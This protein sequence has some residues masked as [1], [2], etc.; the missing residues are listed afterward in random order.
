MATTED[1]LDAAR[2]AKDVAKITALTLI[3]EHGDPVAALELLASIEDEE[4]PESMFELDAV[5]LSQQA[6][7]EAVAMGVG[8]Q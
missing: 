4:Q 3:R 5:L 8:P 2:V 6:I 7:R 1:L